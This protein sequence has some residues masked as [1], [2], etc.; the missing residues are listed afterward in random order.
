MGTGKT[1]AATCAG[2][3]AHGSGRG[4]KGGMLHMVIKGNNDEEE[5]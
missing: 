4:E 5:G 1:I 3:L 2:V